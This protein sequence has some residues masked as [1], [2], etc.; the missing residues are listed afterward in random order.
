MMEAAVSTALTGKT[1][2]AAGEELAEAVTA[3]HAMAAA[4]FK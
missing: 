1:M 3:P 2:N 4:E